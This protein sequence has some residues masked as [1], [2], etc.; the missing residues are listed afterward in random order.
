MYN[1]VSNHTRFK[2]KS[3]IRFIQSYLHKLP[4]VTPIGNLDDLNR[5]K[6]SIYKSDK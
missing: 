6:L 2:I 3:Y 1:Y 5:P 4:E